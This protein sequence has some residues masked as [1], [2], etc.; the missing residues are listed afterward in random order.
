MTTASRYMTG[1]GNE[2]ET[3]ALSG[4]LPVG[5]NSPQRA[6]YGLYAEQISGSA[7]TAP[8]HENRRSWFYR[9]RPAAVHGEFVPHRHD[10]WHNRFDEAEPSPNQLRWS[11]RPIPKAPADFVDGLYTMAG[12]GS[13]ASQSGIGVYV[14]AAN[15]SMQGRFLYS[16]D[17]ELLIVPQLGRLRLA[18]E[19][20]LIDVEPQQVALIPRGIRFRVELLDGEARGYVCENFGAAL[21]LPYL[22]PIG[23]N[24]LANPRDFETPV[25]WYE[26]EV[27]EYELI[28]KF[29]GAL[30]RAPIG[31]SPLDVVA[32]H[33]NHAPCRYDLR[34]FNTIG[35]ISFDHP[36]PSIFTVLTSPS[37]TPGTANLD[38][39]IFPPRWLVGTDTFRPPWF[40]RNVASEF[41]GLIHGVYDAKAEGFLPGGASL[42][43][44]MSGHGPDAE[45]FA[46]ASAADTT[47]PEHIRD[48]MAFMFETRAVIRPTRQALNADWRQRNYQDCWA[49]LVRHFDPDRR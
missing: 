26:D 15:R 46:K 39:V 31:H 49:G 28:A 10:H 3:E 13:A 4:A 42:H 24:G 32:W 23:A 8:R 40:H 37:D 44:C 7:F 27:G 6:P 20:G 12:N 21:R 30:W 47:K 2:F 9:I 38:F 45:T 34:R 11:P 29:Q 5:R 19:C 22:G 33:G 36:D 25:A 18:T 48:T 35:S 41:M 14:Y 16:A 1:F 17:G 43:N